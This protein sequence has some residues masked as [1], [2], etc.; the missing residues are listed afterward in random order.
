MIFLLISVLLRS[1]S[2]T[3]TPLLKLIDFINFRN[4]L[5]LSNFYQVIS[6]P[7]S[8]LSE[9]FPVLLVIL[10]SGAKDGSNS[11]GASFNDFCDDV[12]GTT[13]F[14][15]GI[16]VVVEMFDDDDVAD[17]GGGIFCSFFVDS[18]ETTRNVNF[19]YFLPEK[20]TLNKFSA[21]LKQQIQILVYF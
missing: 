9:K 1:S 19:I 10:I 5:I 15:T 17:S 6:G 20:G 2:V 13:E 16:L 11:V 12:N 14:V 3:S 7:F 18:V 8:A 4:I 21:K